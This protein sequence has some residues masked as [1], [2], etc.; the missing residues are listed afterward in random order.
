MN[1]YIRN[2]VAAVIT[3]FLLSLSAAV[4]SDSQTAFI[5]GE[6]LHYTLRWGFIPAGEAELKVMP[7]ETI[8]GVQVFH[9]AMTARTNAFIDAFYRFQTRID[10]YA[11]LEMTRSI[12]YIKKT[13]LRRK[14]K[15]DTINFDWQ[16]N[17][18][19]F[20]RREVLEGSPPEIKYQNQTTP[21]MAG[22]FDP[23]SAFYFTRTINLDRL[24]HL[25]RPVSDG[26]KCV[27]AKAQI[28]KREQIKIN[29]RT[30]DSFMIMPDL[31]NVRGVIPKSK[32]AKIHIWVSA[33][34]YQIPL[35]IKSKVVVG[36]FTGE[37]VQVERP[38]KTQAGA[39]QASLS[40]G[41]YCCGETRK[42][43]P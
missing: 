16:Q 5:P 1:C 27:V 8:D 20:H 28:L 21:L 14:Q 26:K 41:N 11:D 30:Y 37:L 36:S 9:F 35:R 32:N 6:I 19:R 34:R 17:E 29:G 23:L 24:A 13:E 42:V 10:A 38:V 40:S 12:K 4:A 22:S 33:D 7:V 18:A 39:G 15:V 43:Y 25:E 31:Q 3:C 2:Q